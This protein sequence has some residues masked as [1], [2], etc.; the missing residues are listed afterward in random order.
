MLCL[1]GRLA[2]LLIKVAPNVYKEFVTINK[3]G[4]TVLY[5]HIL[6][7]VYRI[8]K[9]VLLY[10]QKF[11]KDKSIGFEINPYNACVANKMDKRKQITI[12]WYVNDLKISHMSS[13]VIDRLIK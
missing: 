8:I 12:V 1:F 3:K 10:Y 7:A 11:V 6:N 13:T 5:V 9:L 2:N 4:E